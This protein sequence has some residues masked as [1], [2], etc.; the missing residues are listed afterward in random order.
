MRSLR[1]VN[2]KNKKGGKKGGK[3]QRTLRKMNCSPMVKGKTALTDSCFTPE[4]MVLLKTSYN[5]YHPD[6][7]I[8]STN[9]D[10]IWHELKGR[11]S[12]CDKEDCWLSQI[13]D[14]ALRKKID[15]YSFAPD[16]PKEWAKKPSEWLSN[17]DIMEVLQQYEQTYGSISIDVN[18]SNTEGNHDQTGNKK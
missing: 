1:N 10:Q 9:S 18:S 7:K 3:K 15:L 11:L 5:K 17:Y 13:Q 4:T 6:N 16:Q 8:T 12:Q 14:P 2:N